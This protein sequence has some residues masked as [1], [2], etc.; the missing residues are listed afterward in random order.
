[1]DES[2]TKDVELISLKK[3]DYQH[4]DNN[5]T[6]RIIQSTRIDFSKNQISMK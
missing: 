4:L 1:M 3:Y 5:D 2:T 6:E